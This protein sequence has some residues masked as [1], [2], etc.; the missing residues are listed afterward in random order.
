MQNSLNWTTHK[1][2]VKP[3]HRGGRGQFAIEEIKAN[4]I[5]VV[6]GGYVYTLN[7]YQSLPLRL[8]EFSYQVQHSPVLLYGPIDINQI[9]DGEFF[10]HSCSPNSGFLTTIHLVA[11]RDIMPGEEVTFDYAMCMTNDF[12]NMKCDCR[13]PNCRGYI[14]GDDWKID[15]LQRSYQ[16]YFQPYIERLIKTNNC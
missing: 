12:G 10:N 1:I 5:I 11:M 14:T 15:S 2:A 4:E 3:D 16:G 13:S 7:H 9:S 8:Q 6:Y